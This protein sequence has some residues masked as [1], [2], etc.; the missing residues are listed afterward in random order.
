MRQ[1]DCMSNIDL[2]AEMAKI[3][4]YLYK[5]TPEAQRLYSD[6]EN[7][8]DNK[9]HVGVMAQELQG[10]PVTAHT[11]TENEDGYLT[12][13]TRQLTLALTAVCSDLA[14]KVEELENTVN[15]LKAKLEG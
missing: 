9:E 11:V 8:V 1:G 6:G 12:V 5:Y 3:N 7:A 10:N 4:S 14:K 13:D 15:E 2:T